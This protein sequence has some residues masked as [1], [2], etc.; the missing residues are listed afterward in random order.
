MSEEA[1]RPG[2]GILLVLSKQKWFPHHLYQRSLFPKARQVSQKQSSYPVS[3]PLTTS[4]YLMLI[5]REAEVAKR[6]KIHTSP[7]AF[8]AF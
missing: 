3:L 1:P 7:F 8:P 2:P 5:S 4:A 6:V